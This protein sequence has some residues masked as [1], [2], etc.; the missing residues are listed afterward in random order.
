MNGELRFPEG[1]LWGTA[2]AAYQVEGA[3]Q[4]DGRG[5]SIWDTFAKTPGKVLNG[6]TGDVACDHYHRYPED[7]R[8]M[9][10]LGMQAYRFSIAW[11]R[12]FPE[13]GRYNPKGTDFYKRLVDTLHQHGILPVATIYHWDLP[14]W[15]QD[16]GG[17][18][19]RRSVDYFVEYANTLFRELGDVVPLWITHNEPWCVSFLSHW[20]GQHAPG[21]RD[22]REALQVAHHVLLSHGRTVQAYREA[23]LS[24]RIG[25]TLNLTVVDAASEDPA[26]LRAAQIS[27]GNANRWFLDPI[28]RGSYPADMVEIY[29]EQ[30]GPFDFVHADDLDIIR[31]PIDFLGVNYY[32]RSVVRAGED[33]MPKP[34]PPAGPVTD[35]GWEV[36]PESLYR[37]LTRLRREY[38]GLPLY[39]TEN[40]AAYPDR[41]V[42]GRVDDPE[43]IAYLRDHFAAAHRFIQEGGN[44]QGYFVWSFMDNFEWAFGY[45][46]RFGL[47]YVDY[48][49]Q[50]RIPKASA[51]WYRDVI[52]ANGIR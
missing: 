35:M 40:G 12:I 9:K 32:T 38:T 21:H 10:E 36:H 18:A 14:Q 16:E 22:L 20:L 52:A 7:V 31:R 26:D 44:L 37:L 11:P 3:A 25:I 5:P 46:K 19:N 8:L 51:L 41:V 24:G 2:T 47:V 30:A 39:I 27:D 48:A 50:T 43:R 1:F 33:G 17:W 34:V 6:D 29:T 15:I 28:F 4:E 45:S 49:T 13:K 23:G 42:D